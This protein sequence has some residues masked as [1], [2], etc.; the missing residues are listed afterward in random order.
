MKAEGW[1]AEVGLRLAG[2]LWRAP[3]GE[4]PHPGCGLPVWSV[5]ES[6]LG[7]KQGTGRRADSAGLGQSCCWWDVVPGLDSF[8]MLIEREQRGS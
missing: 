7:W 1:G 3:R 4:R 6:F 2:G 8:L 5:D